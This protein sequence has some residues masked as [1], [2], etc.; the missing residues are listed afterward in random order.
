M[1]KTVAVM[2]FA[3]LA[4]GCGDTDP[5]IRARVETQFAAEPLVNQHQIAVESREGVVTLDGVVSSQ[6]ARQRAEELA[7]S[8]EGVVRVINTLEV[9]P[10]APATVGPR[11]DVPADLN[12]A[13]QILEEAIEETGEAI[14][15]IPENLDDV[16]A[17]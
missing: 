15:Q 8:T 9:S 14:K 17:P 12:Q 11:P 6:D 16:A 5:A 13:G 4:A 7:R 1:N 2:L 3:M 10:A